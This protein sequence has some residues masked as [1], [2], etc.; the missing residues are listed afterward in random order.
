M[1]NSKTYQTF[2]VTSSELEY[3]DRS[4]TMLIASL[5]DAAALCIVVKCWLITLQIAVDVFSTYYVELPSACCTTI[6]VG[7]LS[8][9][10]FTAAFTQ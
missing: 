8:M 7:M 4:V 2:D 3:G 1:K 10:A 6:Y 9:V 5:S